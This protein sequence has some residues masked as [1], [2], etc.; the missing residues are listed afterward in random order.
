M[1]EN[2]SFFQQRLHERGKMRG[3]QKRE[4]TLVPSAN[5]GRYSLDTE[6]GQDITS[7]QSI[8]VYLGGRWIAGHVEHAKDGYYFLAQDYTVCGLIAG[9]K[10]RITQP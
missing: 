1:N 10:V 7:G 3:E 9:V 4:H 2:R 8:E 5:Q 6:G